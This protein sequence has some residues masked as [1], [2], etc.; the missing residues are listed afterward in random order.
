MEP[1]VVLGGQVELEIRVFGEL[2]AG[3]E[4]DVEAR[5]AQVFI[6]GVVK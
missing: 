5:K 1:F 6:R 4:L 2:S 3:L